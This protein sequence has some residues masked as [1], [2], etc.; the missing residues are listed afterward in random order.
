M[1]F[2][3][4]DPDIKTIYT[5][6]SEGDYDLQPDFQRGEVWDLKKKRRLIDTILREWHIPPIHLVEI[7]R[8]G[9]HEVLDG[10]QRLV[11]IRDFIDNQF[12]VNGKESP[13]DEY[14]T[15]LDGLR[16]RE[17]PTDVK[18]KFDQFSLR[19]FTIIDYLPEEPGELFYRLNQSTTLSPAEQRNSFYG[20]PRNQIKNLTEF[21]IEN[22]VDKKILGFSNARMAFDDM[23]AK[24][25]YTLENKSFS[26]SIGSKVITEKYRKGEAFD[27]EAVIKTKKAISLFAIA[28]RNFEDS[29]RFNKS[30]M[31]SWLIFLS[32]LNYE[33]VDKDIIGKFIFEFEKNRN[34]VNQELDIYEQESTERLYNIFNDR[35]SSRAENISSI[36]IR[37][38]VLWLNFIKFNQSFSLDNVEKSSLLNQLFEII[39]D[40]RSEYMTSEILEEFLESGA[41]SGNL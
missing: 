13:A 16:Y 25:C 24:V 32:Q 3:S 40:A 1:F 22:G 31:Y 36:K 28:A 30:T 9:K 11:A 27:E 41:W 35:A 19:I 17:L 4:T 23:L 15:K 34:N 8:S 18:K 38:L 37:D 5:R 2:K 29:I 21:M 20:T 6:I 7:E 14:V 33:E 12:S 26:A 39:S 10:Q